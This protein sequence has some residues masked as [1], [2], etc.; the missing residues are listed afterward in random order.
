V[1]Q[2]ARKP[3][4]AQVDRAALF[5]AHR[6]PARDFIKCSQAAAAYVIA[7]HSRAMTYAGRIC[8]NTG[9]FGV[10][11]WHGADYTCCGRVICSS[12]ASQCKACSRDSPHISG[13][14]RS[15]AQNSGR[16]GWPNTL[17]PNLS[18]SCIHGMPAGLPLG[19]PGKGEVMEGAMQQAAQWRR[20]FMGRDYSGA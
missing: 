6:H 5:L 3:G 9:V 18:S 1:L 19:I 8:G 15:P 10:I 13:E 7:Q 17:Q 12:A 4:N 20:Q 11:G 2:V 14:G 16:P